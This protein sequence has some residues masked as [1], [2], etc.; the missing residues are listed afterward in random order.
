MRGM[1][2]D[3]YILLIYAVSL[4]MGNG[5]VSQVNRWNDTEARSAQIS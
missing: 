5:V 3:D 2:C 4:L 1:T